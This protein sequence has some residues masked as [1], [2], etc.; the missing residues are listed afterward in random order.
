ME[1]ERVVLLPRGVLGRD[2]ELGEVEIVGL[3][4]RTFGDGEAHVA[5]DLDALVEH[6]ADGMDAPVLQGPRRTGSVMSAFSLAS[7]RRKRLRSS[8]ALRPSS[9]SLTRVL[10][11]VDGLA[12]G[13]ALLRRQRAERR[14]QLGDAALLAERGDAHLLDA[15]QIGGAGDLAQELA[16]ERVEVGASCAVMPAETA[17]Q[18]RRECRDPRRRSCRQ[19]SGAGTSRAANCGGSR[20]EHRASDL[21]QL[22]GVLEPPA[23]ASAFLTA[24]AAW[25]TSALKPAASCDGEIGQHLAVDV[26]ARPC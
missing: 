3:D 18:P 16:L 4:V 22:P 15:R 17:R 6:L 12:E 23:L 21:R 24:A 10:E 13:L 20:R 2:V 8:S 9:A 11:P 1:I 7:R 19:A 5:E 25:S 26:D 14:H